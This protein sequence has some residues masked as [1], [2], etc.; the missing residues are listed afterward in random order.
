VRS[1]RRQRAGRPRRRRA[2]DPATLLLLSV[3]L[4]DLTLSEG[5]GAYGAPEDPLVPVSELARLL[6]ADIDVLPAEGRIV[7]RLGEA[8]R[9]LVVDLKTGVRRVAAPGDRHPP[10]TRSSRPPR[11]TARLDC[12]KLLPLRSRSPP[13]TWRCAC[14]PSRSS[15]I[16]A[17][18]RAPR[19]TARTGR[20]RRVAEEAR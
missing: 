15:P 14:T 13:T 4:D 5:L 1:L 2:L 9:S 19:P 8:R 6:E 11:S 20:G 12:Q 3:S 7:G 10:A 16:Q 18:L 17:R